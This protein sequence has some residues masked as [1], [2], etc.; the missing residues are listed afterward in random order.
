MPFEHWRATVK[1]PFTKMQGAGNDFVVID[2]FSNHIE[3]TTAQIR[4][5]ADRHFGV[6]ADQVLLVEKPTEEGADFKY[7]IFNQDGGEVEMCGNGARCFAKFV[8]ERGLTDKS[9]IRVETMKGI[10]EPCLLDDGTVQVD[11][12]TPVFTPSA[13]PFNPAGLATREINGFRQWAV[14]FK[15]ELHWFSVC[16]MGN[17]H[18]TL[19][20]DDVETAPVEELGSFIENHPAFPRRVNVGF[21]QILNPRLA[22]VRVWER[23][24]G[25]TLAC[26]T[27]NSAAYCTSV[28]LML[29]DHEAL[30]KNH[31]GDLKFEWE[32]EGMPLL[33]SGPAVTVFESEISI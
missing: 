31:G 27:G 25:E 2:A 3:L 29:M 28:Q 23:G 13:L 9:R 32:G 11:M 20:V 6:G 22:K 26:G 14:E 33:M 17:P 16:S 5:L 8:R 12:G 4:A 30:L 19:V 18:A 24:A 1:I 15:G 10:I 7:R 21:I